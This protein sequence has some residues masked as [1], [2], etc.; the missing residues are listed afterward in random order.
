MRRVPPEA[1]SPGRSTG[2]TNW[3]TSS[4]HAD[5]YVSCPSTSFA[6]T[7]CAA[8][9]LSA[10]EQI[11]AEHLPGMARHRI[12]THGVW[13]APG[14]GTPRLYA[15]VSYRYTD[16]VQERLEAYLSS[17]ELHADMEGFDIS[18]IVGLD[19][20]PLTPTADSPLRRP[21]YDVSPGKPRRHGLRSW[22]LR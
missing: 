8:R 21:R 13:T 19:E 9:T 12:T 2:A 15:L 16:D 22:R 17:P 20:T 3:R 18:Q 4:P 14:D 11:W 6:S 10:Y 1:V 7:P 5:A